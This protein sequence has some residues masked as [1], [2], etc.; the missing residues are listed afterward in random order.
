MKTICSALFLITVAVVALPSCSCMSGTDALEL[1]RGAQSATV[2]LEHDMSPTTSICMGLMQKMDDPTDFQILLDR[3]AVLLDEA[4]AFDQMEGIN[5]TMDWISETIQQSS[6]LN[7]HL[8][9]ARL[10]TWSAKTKLRALKRDWDSYNE[11]LTRTP[12]MSSLEDKLEVQMNCQMFEDSLDSLR[13]AVILLFD[14]VTLIEQWLLEQ[15]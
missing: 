6:G 15:M 10:R 4:C 1:L 3:Y 9:A 2:K 8:R 5:A 13:R 12:D 7:F 14:G 11:K